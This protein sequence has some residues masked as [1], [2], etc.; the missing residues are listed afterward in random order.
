MYDQDGMHQQCVEAVDR[1]RTSK[2]WTPMRFTRMPKPVCQKL[3]LDLSGQ[4]R[5]CGKA[6]EGG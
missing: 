5:K 2:S 6:S 4:K 3:A 1:A